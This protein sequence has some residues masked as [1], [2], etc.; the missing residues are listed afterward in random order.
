FSALDPRRLRQPALHTERA[1]APSDHEAGGRESLSPLSAVHAGPEGA[2][3][4]DGDPAPHP[5]GVLRRERSRVRESDCR[6]DERDAGLVVLR[7]DLQ[8]EQLSGLLIT[9]HSSAIL[10]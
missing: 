3:A 6:Y 4:E 9:G 2:R 10:R 5:T 1:R 8:R 7:V